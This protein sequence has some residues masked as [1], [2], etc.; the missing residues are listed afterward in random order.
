MRMACL[1]RCLQKVAVGTIHLV[2][3]LVNRSFDR[4]TGALNIDQA[5]RVGWS[6]RYS[7][8]IEERSNQAGCT[9]RRHEIKP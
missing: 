5:P 8:Y 4:F 2:D 9:K 7:V 3:D 1:I 6:Q